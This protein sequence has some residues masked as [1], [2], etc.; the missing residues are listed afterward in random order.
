M[1]PGLVAESTTDHAWGAGVERNDNEEAVEQPPRGRD[2]FPHQSNRNV[3]TDDSSNGRSS[4][5]NIGPEAVLSRG[6]LV[7]RGEVIAQAQ[8]EEDE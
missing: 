5:R 6:R 7:G 1:S 4:R 8:C 2:V 3:S